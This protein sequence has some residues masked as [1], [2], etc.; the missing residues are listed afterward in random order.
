MPRMFTIIKDLLFKGNS[1]RKPAGTIPVKKL[2]IAGFF[3][4]EQDKAAWFGHSTVLLKIDGR[5]LLLDPTFASSPSPFPL[6]G[7]KRFS[8]VLPMEPEAL[9]AIDIVM[10]SHDHYDHLDYKSVMLLKDKTS[11]FCVPAGVGARL[12]SW[13][14]SREK[15]REFTWW[16]EVKFTGLTLVCTPARHFSG[17]SLRDRNTTAWCSWTVIGRKTR[18]FFSG[19]GGYGPHFAG[20]GEKYGPFDLTLLE[21]GQYDVRWADIHMLPE[22]T[23]QAHSDLRGRML[24]PVHWAA[25]SLAFH[26]WTE[27]IERATKAA[28][29]RNVVIATPMIGEIINIGANEYPQAVWW[30]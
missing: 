22:E 11:M 29:E 4:D 5:I 10:V 16:D 15:I 14:I 13:G 3:G 24:V 12:N 26:S 7:G 20:I 6:I 23:V 1:V 28:Q 2:D 19:D 9:P 21:C 17:R 8:G 27:P 30:K 25:F 18:V